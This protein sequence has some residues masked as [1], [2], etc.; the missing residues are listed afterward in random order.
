MEK[1]IVRAEILKN[2]A[3]L[4]PCLNEGE[5]LINTVRDL[6]NELGNDFEENKYLKNQSFFKII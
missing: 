1:I 6:E 3:I 2:P 5:R 4:V